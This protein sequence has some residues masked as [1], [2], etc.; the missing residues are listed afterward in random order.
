MDVR[1]LVFGSWGAGAGFKYTPTLLACAL[2]PYLADPEVRAFLPRKRW[3]VVHT[4]ESSVNEGD[5]SMDVD[6]AG[7]ESGDERL[8]IVLDGDSETYLIAPGPGPSKGMCYLS[9]YLH[10]LR[11]GTGRTLLRNLWTQR[12]FRRLCLCPRRFEWNR[13]LEK[14]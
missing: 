6:G 13:V 2:F 10:L 9:S 12:S 3:K 14:T 11:K 7:D 4:Q 5:A 1:T 8:A